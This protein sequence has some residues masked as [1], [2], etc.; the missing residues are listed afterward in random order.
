MRKGTAVPGPGAEA[1]GTDS[2]KKM[3]ELQRV[4]KDK[5]EHPPL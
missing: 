4:G 5:G 1:E 3:G 2:R